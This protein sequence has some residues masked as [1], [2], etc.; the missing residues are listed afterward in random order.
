L[1]LIKASGGANDEAA[2][3]NTLGAA[4]EFTEPRSV[5]AWD[6]WFRWRHAGLLR[7]VSIDHTWQR[8]ANALAGHDRPTCEACVDA[9]A[10]WRLLPDERLLARAGTGLPCRLDTAPR[11]VLVLPGFLSGAVAAPRF[12]WTLLRST[13]R[14]AVRA[15]EGVRGESS[16]PMSVGIG[17]IGLANALQRLQLD[18][19]SDA[20]RDF[21]RQ[22]GS[23]LAHGCLEASIELAAARG[24]ATAPTADQLQRWRAR[25]IAPAL[26]DAALRSGVAHDRLTSFERAPRLALLANDVADALD[27]LM[28]G[29]ASSLAH[30]TTHAA[31][32]RAPERIDA[33][34]TSVGPEAQL[35]MRAVMSPFADVPIDHHLHVRQAPNERER[36]ALLALTRNLGLPTPAFRRFHSLQVA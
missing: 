2:A 27:P 34:A 31:S 29:T 21:A 24:T 28:G 9:F 6:A 12:D 26:V 20:G 30:G 15:L 19:D 7:D 13:A 17:L 11:A 25:G 23:T 4:T 5:E 18:Y 14:L 33:A 35:R 36:E 16:G 8:V 22:V 3:M 10:R 32:R 1:I